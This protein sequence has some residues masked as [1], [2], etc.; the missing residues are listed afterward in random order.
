MTESNGKLKNI[1][2]KILGYT[3]KSQ[4]YIITL[5]SDEVQ[6]RVLAKL[7]EYPRAKCPHLWRMRES[8]TVGS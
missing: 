2:V 3:K 6:C 7:R 4:T 5:M 8:D 1:G